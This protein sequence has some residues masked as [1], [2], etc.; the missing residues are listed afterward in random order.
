[1]LPVICKS[2][3]PTSRTA[4]VTALDADCST[5]SWSEPGLAFLANAARTCQTHYLD[6]T[7]VVVMIPIIA[8]AVGCSFP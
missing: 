3:S 8:G 2:H 6:T 7:K 4:P 5:I 1:M